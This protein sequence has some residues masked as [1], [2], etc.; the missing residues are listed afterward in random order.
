MWAVVWVI[1]RQQSAV[2]MWRDAENKDKL[3]DEQPF[4]S[5]K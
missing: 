5:L 2:S 3:L 1:V 4:D